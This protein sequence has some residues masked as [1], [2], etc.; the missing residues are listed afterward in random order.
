[1]QVPPVASTRRISA[2]MRERS[3]TC[4]STFEREYN[5]DAGIRQWNGPTV[6][7]LDRKNA[8]GGIVRIRDLDRGNLET[9]PLQFQSLLT[10]TGP[11]FENA[12]A[13][14]KQRSNL[15]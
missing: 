6:V 15:F 5:V 10:G 2:C 7:I 1:M 9:A 12:R 3:A 4:S 11:D 13:G 14:W 8:V